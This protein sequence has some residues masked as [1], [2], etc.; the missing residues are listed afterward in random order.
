VDSSP[1]DPQQTTND[2]QFVFLDAVARGESHLV[3][4]TLATPPQMDANAVHSYDANE[5]F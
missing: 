2:H 1:H 5:Q 4:W 3:R